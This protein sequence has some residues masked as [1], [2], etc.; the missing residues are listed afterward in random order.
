MLYM[1]C[2]WTFLTSMFSSNTLADILS[3]LELKIQVILDLWSK[4]G[5]KR[6][7]LSDLVVKWVITWLCP[8]LTLF[9]TIVKGIWLPPLIFLIRKRLARSP[10]AIIWLWDSVSIGIYASCKCPNFNY[11]ITGMLWWVGGPVV[12]IFFFP[13]AQLQLWAVIKQMIL[14][15]GLPYSSANPL[16]GRDKV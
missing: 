3:L 13:A 11:V 9:A 10:I 8:I 12:N 6:P 5:P 2:P 15:L 4:L 14:N 1:V 16:W 7:S